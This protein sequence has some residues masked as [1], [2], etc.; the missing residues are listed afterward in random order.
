M[1]QNKSDRRKFLRGSLLALGVAA[2]KPVAAA[3][4]IGA[5]E[6]QPEGPFYP[7]GLPADRDNDLTQVQGK[8]DKALGKEMFL[9]GQVLDNDCRPVAGALVEIWQAC[10]S[11]KYNHSG[12]PNPAE[13]DPNFQYYG[14]AVTD[15][16]G[17]Y[18]FKTIKPGAYPASR[19]WVRPPHI[20]MKVLKRGFHEL[21]TQMYF[22]EESQLN[23]EDR[24]LQSL[25]KAEQKE[26]QIYPDAFTNLGYNT[27]EFNISLN[28]V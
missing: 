3:C 6:Q 28:K 11:G 5:T 24:I 1:E 8:E 16:V 9:V 19:D 13:L 18:S 27:Y 26:V 7:E 20:H 23:S 22:A 2:T 12:D 10:A 15:D 17:A 4:G 21:T 14:K 25:S